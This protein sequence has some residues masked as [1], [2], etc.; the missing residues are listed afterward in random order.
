MLRLRWSVKSRNVFCLF[1]LFQITV[2]FIFNL[3]SLIDIFKNS[4]F[5]LRETTKICHYT[6]NSFSNSDPVYSLHKS[7]RSYSLSNASYT[8]YLFFARMHTHSHTHTHTHTNTLSHTQISTPTHTQ[9][10]THP[11]IHSH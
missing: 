7:P 3:Q 8:R 2:F 10:H 4:F 6:H 9:T 5:I 1:K 11:N